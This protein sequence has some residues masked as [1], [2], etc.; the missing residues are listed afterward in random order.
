[1]LNQ[2][3]LALGEYRTDNFTE[4]GATFLCFAFFMLATFFTQVTMLNMVIAI[5]SDTFERVSEHKELNARRTKLDLL[6][7][8]AGMLK[9]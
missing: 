5:M 4:S 7:D 3:Y 8:F 9:E 6:G 1:M 2:Y